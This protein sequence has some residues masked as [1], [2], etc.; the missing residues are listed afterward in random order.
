MLSARG[1]RLNEDGDSNLAI[2]VRRGEHAC[3]MI[4]ISVASRRPSRHAVPKLAWHRIGTVKSIPHHSSSTQRCCSNQFHKD[5]ST[6]ITL[7]YANHTPH[8]KPSFVYLSI[9][10]IGNG[11][12]VSF[13]LFF[14]QD[15]KLSL[16]ALNGCHF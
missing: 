2:R 12:Q 9:R 1:A 15:G 4:T 8:S 6:F 7:T 10:I 16:L 14:R 5:C 13:N 3:L 11:I